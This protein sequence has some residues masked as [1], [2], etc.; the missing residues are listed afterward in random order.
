MGG[1]LL[2][3][4]TGTARV[5]VVNER[6]TGMGEIGSCMMILVRGKGTVKESSMHLFRH[7][8]FSR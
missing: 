8:V 7:A 4:M 5:G 1:E 6:R 3:W 2:S